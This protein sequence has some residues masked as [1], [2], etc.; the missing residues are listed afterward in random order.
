L[1]ASE[2][3]PVTTAE[4]IQAFIDI[5]SIP[6][7]KQSLLKH[8]SVSTINF[9]SE[10]LFLGYLQTYFLYCAARFKDTFNG[11]QFGGVIPELKRN[12][13]YESDYCGYAAKMIE[14]IIS[15]R[16]QAASAVV[17]P[18]SGAGITITSTGH[19]HLDAQS[20]QLRSANP[21]VLF[22]C[23][24]SVVAECHAQMVKLSGQQTSLQAPDYDMIE[25]DTSTVVLPTLESILMGSVMG[26]NGSR[27]NLAAACT[28]TG[29]S[30]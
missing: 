10:E 7:S 29:F 21:G 18:V 15:F 2:L 25:A 23:L 24:K 4:A 12:A 3:Q 6:T 13:K 8:D 1:H 5:S 27:S 22:D 9:A 26:G 17:P 30:R 16:T 28:T 11:S 14:Q 20:A 19:Y